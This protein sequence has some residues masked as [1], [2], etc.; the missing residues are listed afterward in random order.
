MCEGL[1]EVLSGLPAHSFTFRGFP[2]RKRAARRRFFAEDAA[3][4]HSLIY[5]E[6]P[7][8][9]LATLSDA[10][11]VLGNRPAAVANDLTKM[12]E[13]V[14]RDS[15]SRLVELFQHEPLRGEYVVV[16]EGM[17]KGGEIRE[18]GKTAKD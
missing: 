11:E 6:S 4:P 5:Y 2:P 16:I 17:L 13:T 10:L 18:S 15:L 9:L 7:Y 1:A 12:F 3:Q 8:R 14:Y